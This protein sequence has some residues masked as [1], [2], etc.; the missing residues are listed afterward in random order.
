MSVLKSRIQMR[1][2]T[3]ATRTA[4]ADPLDS[5]PFYD[6][7]TNTIWV[8]EGGWQNTGAAGSIPTTPYQNGTDGS[9]THIGAAG[10]TTITL[11]TTDI[12]K[13]T[14]ITIDG[15]AGIYTHTITLSTSN[16]NA[17]DI[18]KLTLIFPASSQPTIEVHNATS[19]GTNMQT[20]N[21]SD[22]ESNMGW[23]GEFTYDGAA[24]YFSGGEWHLA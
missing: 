10:N 11:A 21:N 5:E 18:H 13:R 23:T 4:I 2:G 1:S 14:K 20:L 24:W 15:G 19:G 8:Y 6:T 9:G 16:A 12:A 7:D 22:G 3:T 17:G